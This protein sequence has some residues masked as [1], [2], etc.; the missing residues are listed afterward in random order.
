MITLGFFCGG[1][2]GGAR[3]AIVSGSLNFSLLNSGGFDLPLP[4]EVTFFRVGG[5]KVDHSESGEDRS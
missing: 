1:S 5:F 2:F 4:L 3:D